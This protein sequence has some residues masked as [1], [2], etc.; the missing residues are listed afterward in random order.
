MLRFIRSNFA[1]PGIVK[2]LVHDLV[3]KNQPL[4]KP[5]SPCPVT[6]TE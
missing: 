6:G 3:T 4:F 5:T 1:A 2:R